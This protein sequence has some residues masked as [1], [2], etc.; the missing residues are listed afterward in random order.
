VSIPS[1]LI[2]G[3]GEQV[4]QVNENGMAHLWSID[5]ARKTRTVL[6]EGLSH[7]LPARDPATAMEI[8]RMQA[9]AD[10]RFIA[11]FQ[12]HAGRP[13]TLGLWDLSSGQALIHCKGAEAN[14]PDW[15]MP[16]QN[17]RMILSAHPLGQLR[18]WDRP[19][20]DLLHEFKGA[21][22]AMAPDGRRLLLVHENKRQLIEIPSGAISG[23]FESDH[24][25][26][27]FGPNG[28]FLYDPVTIRDAVT[29]IPID[30]LPGGGLPS[31]NRQGSAYLT[32]GSNGVD[33]WDL[34][35]DQR[36]VSDIGYWIQGNLPLVYENGML[37]PR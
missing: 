12:L 5:K 1:A 19:T 2:L 36:P 28:R 31:L 37:M 9:L 30:P 11:G 4:V 34:N 13:T 6:L 23:L 25:D 29:G 21:C 8:L 26:Y 10:D 35:L 16:I 18:L 22:G 27:L 20:G 14:S 7:F 32:F 3:S 17:G 15:A 33:C 24:T